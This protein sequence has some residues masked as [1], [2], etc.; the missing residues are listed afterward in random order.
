M[1][2]DQVSFLFLCIEHAG[3][4]DFAG[5]ARDYEKIHGE[6]LSAGAAQKRFKRLKD[7][8]EKNGQGS[9]KTNGATV[10]KWEE[11]GDRKRKIGVEGGTRKKVKED[12][13]DEQDDSV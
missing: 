3:K 7:K 11:D 9:S 12:V 1:N 8:M 2:F 5:V 4:V 6:K 10:V 13:K